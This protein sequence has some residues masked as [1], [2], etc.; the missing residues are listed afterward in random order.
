MRR[1]AIFLMPLLL[2]A[3]VVDRIAVSVDKRVITEADLILD[4]RVSAF[5]DHKP[6]DLSIAAKRA[7]AVRLVDRTLLL[8]EASTSHEDLST[9]YMGCQVDPKQ[10]YSTDAEYRAALLEY[11]L[12]EDQLKTHLLDGQHACEFSDSRFGPEVQ[13]TEQELHDAYTTYAADWAKAH[14]NEAVPTFDQSREEIEQ[15]LTVQR[16]SAKLDVW[17][18]MAQAE[19]R[20]EYREAAFQ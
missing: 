20:I 4:L 7:A 11:H 5:L 18:E 1:I 10:S 6:V 2:R 19:H 8:Q 17:L 12:T 9:D 15:L 3:A 13:I 14:P 16:I